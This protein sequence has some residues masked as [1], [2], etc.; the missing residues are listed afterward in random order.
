MALNR[1][2]AYREQVGVEGAGLTAA[3]FLARRHRHSS[4]STWTERV[5]GGQVWIDERLASPDARLVPGAW[6]TWNRP[7]WD[8]PEVPLRYQLVAEDEHLLVVS[9]PAGLPTLPAGGFLEHTLLA[10]VRSRDPAWTPLHRLGRGT[11]GLVLFARETAGRSSLA[12]AWRDREVQKHYLAL[13][14]G[15]PPRDRFRVE[16]P[17]GRVEH[18]VLGGLHA[19]V[20]TGRPA[21]SEV[22]VL[23][24]GVDALC[25]VRI[26]TGRPHQIRIHLAH[27][28]HPLVGDPLYGPGGLPR[29]EVRALPGDGGYWLHAHRLALRHPATGEWVRY[30]AEPPVAL[31]RK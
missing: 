28:G 1:G 29:P 11:S 10:L 3:E 8:E 18:P 7:P 21:Q 25:A 17:I 26:Q 14:S 20:A 5:V 31:S 23:H 2:Y 15:A 22:E 12:R 24:R 19:A 4:L 16:A 30:E 6:L 13:A 9:K 27:A